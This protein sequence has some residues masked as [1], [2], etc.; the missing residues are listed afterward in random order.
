MEDRVKKFHREKSRKTARFT[1]RKFGLDYVFFRTMCA[2]YR[3]S[4][5]R[6]SDN[7]QLKYDHFFHLIYCKNFM[8]ETGKEYFTVTDIR[9]FIFDHT[10]RSLS[11]T[12]IYERFVTLMKFDYVM[13]VDK[14]PARNWSVRFAITIRS[15]EFFREFNGIAEI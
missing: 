5:D 2:F 4:R 11:P 7:L 8:I 14:I 3:V 6:R 15:R 9:R 1:V 10:G 12:S 13:I